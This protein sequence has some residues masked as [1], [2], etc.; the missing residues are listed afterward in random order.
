MRSA[1]IVKIIQNL[2][3][4]LGVHEK[5][6]EEMKSEINFMQIELNTLTKLIKK[7]LDK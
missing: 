4:R 7:E 6:V 5:L 2:Q 3:G 1:A